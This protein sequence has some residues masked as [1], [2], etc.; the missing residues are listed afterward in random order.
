MSRFVLALVLLPVL[1]P[2]PAFAGGLGVSFPH[3]TYPET[4]QPV[5]R[6]CGD[7][8]GSTTACEPAS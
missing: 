7:T 5:T 3:L 6:D 2:L 1:A 4:A 8:L